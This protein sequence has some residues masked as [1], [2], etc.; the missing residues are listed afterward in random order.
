MFNNVAAVNGQVGIEH[1]GTN[2]FLQEN[3]VS[4]YNGSGQ[5]M[6]FISNKIHLWFKNPKLICQ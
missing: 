4:A 5:V 1:W 6:A 2:R 3:T